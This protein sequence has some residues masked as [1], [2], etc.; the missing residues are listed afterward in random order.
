MNPLPNPF[1]PR[2]RND[3][4]ANERALLHFMS[5]ACMATT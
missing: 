3:L 1:G 4:S 5:A 2:L